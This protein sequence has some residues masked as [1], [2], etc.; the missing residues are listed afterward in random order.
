MYLQTRIQ[1]L[2]KISRQTIVDPCAFVFAE[3]EPELALRIPDDVLPISSRA[4]NE[5]GP[6]WLWAHGQLLVR[7]IL[8]AYAGA[9]TNSAPVLGSVSPSKHPIADLIKG[10]KGA[11]GQAARTSQQP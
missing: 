6:L 9:M 4:G 11:V 7:R 1:A 8:T 2:D 10:I 3:D 5:E